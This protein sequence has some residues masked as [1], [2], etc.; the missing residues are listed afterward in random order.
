M[1]LQRYYGAA[2]A[3]AVRVYLSLHDAPRAQSEEEQDE[4][5]MAGMNS[6]ERKKY[7]LKKKKEEKAR[8]KEVEEKARREEEKARARREAAAAAGEK[9]KDKKAGGGGGGGQGKEKD[10]DP[11][12]AVLLASCAE[13]PLGAAAKLVAHLKLHR[14]EAVGTQLAASEVYRRRGRLLLALSAVQRAVQA[15]DGGAGHPDVH[16]ALV[17]L[18]AA[19]QQ[20]QQQQGAVQAAATGAAGAAGAGAATTPAQAK[21]VKR[22]LTEGLAALLGGSSLQEYCTAW[23]QRYAAQTPGVGGEGP[24]GSLEQRAAAASAALLLLQGAPEDEV[25]AAKQAALG[26]VLGADLRAAC[27]RRLVAGGCG[28][29]VGAGASSAPGRRVARTGPD[30]GVAVRVHR[31]LSEAGSPLLNADAAAR[32]KAAA[33][34]VFP[35][36]AYFEGGQRVSYDAFE[37]DYVDEAVGR[38]SF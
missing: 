5:A 26:L 1:F 23:Q 33:A 34:T 16:L 35:H 24:V 8:Q 22:V 30:H 27:E 38:L 7:K 18:A 3:G 20:Q 21:V 9:G 10:P 12:G 13:D 36:S 29:S 6:E 25:A 14:P 15:K 37:L 31:L 19:V 17:R 2:A 4:A 11:D 32:F 28:S